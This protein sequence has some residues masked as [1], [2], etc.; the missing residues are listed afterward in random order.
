M[1]IILSLITSLGILSTA[2]S[3]RAADTNVH[4]QLLK[5][6]AIGG[7]GGWDYVSVDAGAR[8][9]YV[10]HAQ[11]VVVV[12]LETNA[13]V[14]EVTGTPGVHGFAIAPDLGRGFASNGQEGTV[15]IVDLKT[16]QTVSKV[17]TGQNPDAILYEPQH[18]EVYAFN[19]RSASAT[20]F[21]AATG[22]VRATIPLPGKPEFAVGDPAAGRI[23]N[24]IED[25]SLV[26]AIDTSAHTVAA[27][28][29]IAPGEEASGLAIDL[30]AHRL[31]IG[32][33]NKL[34]VMMD[35]AS[36]KVLGSVPI[37]P[38][39]DANAF[40]AGIGL[41]FASS[42][43]GT[44]T[45]ARVDA[46]GALQVLQTLDTPRRARTMTIDPTTHRLYVP[47]AEFGTPVAGPDGKPGRPPI[48]PGSFKVMVYE[49]QK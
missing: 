15:S 1:K 49:P 12:D 28:W 3:L 20:V 22:I 14:G 43:D 17:T 18:R 16:L 34:M 30:A 39:V 41:A 9:L 21:D 10:S 42:S 24:N 2:P 27:T 46:Q 13:V 4:Y 36:G 38:G 47:A 40:D 48:V 37:G 44:L 29:P 19:G 6:I 45:V 7:E 35:S 5:A 8:R 23:Y 26:V 32:C 25:K 11:K 33:S 31:F